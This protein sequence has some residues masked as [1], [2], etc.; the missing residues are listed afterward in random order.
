MIPDP[1][2]F[3]IIDAHTHPFLDFQSCIGAYGKPETMEEF[4]REM[5]KV[6]I[7]RYAGAPVVAHPVSDFAGT[8]KL[9][10]DALRILRALRFALPYFFSISFRNWPV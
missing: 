2:E 7:S 3:E 10:E 5:K 4:D 1:A 9:N 8:R 6:G